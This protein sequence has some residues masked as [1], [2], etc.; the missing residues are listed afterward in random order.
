MD[1]GSGLQVNLPKLANSLEV[2]GVGRENQGWHKGF[3]CNS[4][5]DGNA[6]YWNGFTE[7]VCKGKIKSITL[8]IICKAKSMTSLLATEKAFVFC[9]SSHL[10][11]ITPSAMFTCAYQLAFTTS[12]TLCSRTDCGLIQLCAV[13]K[14]SACQVTN[15]KLICWNSWIRWNKTENFIR[16]KS[17]WCHL[18][19]PKDEVTF[20]RCAPVAFCTELFQ[21]KLFWPLLIIR[22][23]QNV[24]SVV[25]LS[26]Q[27]C[28]VTNV[29]KYWWFAKTR[30]TELL[31]RTKIQEHKNSRIMD[32]S[33][34]KRLCL[35]LGF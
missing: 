10:S 28:Q 16:L 5:V 4:W 29:M 30:C 35:L 7:Q 11:I 23:C 26:V 24:C 3:W 9:C 13:G 1:W 20:K 8:V 22:L 25:L 15:V 6:I 21:N 18:S 2:G 32:T 19:R 34:W 14:H 33:S 31:E 12:P 27:V 17:H